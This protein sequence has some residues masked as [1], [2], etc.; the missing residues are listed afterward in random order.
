VLRR[1]RGWPVRISWQ[2]HFASPHHLPKVLDDPTHIGDN[3]RQ[4]VLAFSP[5]AQEVLEKFDLR[6]SSADVA[7]SAH[8]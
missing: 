8:M 1:V 7:V 4:Y 6:P 5:A 2:D 3:L